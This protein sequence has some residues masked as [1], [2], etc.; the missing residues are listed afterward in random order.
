MARAPA[1]VASI[2]GACLP[3]ASN[4][5][6]VMAVNNAPRFSV[7]HV[8]GEE[9]VAAFNALFMASFAVTICADFV[10]NPMLVPLA[11]AAA[12]ADRRA[13]LRVLRFPAVC[14]GALG[15]AALVAGSTFGIRLLGWIFKLDLSPHAGAFRVLLGGGIAVAL[16]QLGQTVLVVLRKQ[17]WGLPGMIAAAAFS[18][19]SVNRLVSRHGMA[20]SAVCYAAAVAMFAVSS[21]SFALFFFARATKKDKQCR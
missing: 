5:F 7:G 11:R 6:L 2:L 19:L 8:L 16:Y 14:I 12:A 15:A 3:L 21:C 17:V 13:A 1:A 18:V 9:S 10:M 20:G 4:S